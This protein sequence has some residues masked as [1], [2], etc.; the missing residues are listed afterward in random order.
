MLKKYGYYIAVFAAYAAAFVLFGFGVGTDCYHIMQQPA[1]LT[2]FEFFNEFPGVPGGIGEYCSCFVEQYFS[3]P[4]FGGFLL[5]VEILLSA[6][7]LI[8]LVGKIFRTEITEK[9][10]LWLVPLFVAV[11]CCNN[12]YFAFHIITQLIIMLAVSVLLHFLPGESRFFWLFEAIAA[13][14]VYH[15]CGPLYLYGFCSGG[16]ILQFLINSERKFVN[17]VSL[18]AVAGVYPLILYRFFLPLPPEPVFYSPVAMK[19][20]LEMYQPWIFMFYLIVPL[21]FVCQ[22]ISIKKR[23]NLWYA[24]SYAAMLGIVIWAYS[25][26]ESRRE[27]F[28]ARIICEAER[29]NWQYVIE[30][31]GKLGRYDRV[32]N[33]YYDLALAKTGLMSSK[34]FEYPQLLGN[35]GLL[36][37]EPL[38]GG[39]C[40][41]SSTQYF[42]IGQIPN[43]LRF[44][45]ESII[46]YKH[47]PYVLKRIIDCLIISEHYTEAEMF[48]K[49]LS[50]N[51]LEGDFVR[52]RR[53]YMRGKSDCQ[54]SDELVEEKQSQRVRL[55]YIMSPAFRNFEELLLAN[56]KNK[57]ATDYLLCYCMLDNDLENFVNTLLASDYSLKNLPKHYQEAVAVYRATSKNPNP[58]IRAAELDQTLVNRFKDFAK[59]ANRPDEKSYR[60]AKQYFNHTYWLYFVFE[61]PMRHNFSLKKHN[62]L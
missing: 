21:S 18:L 47:S 61:N 60:L 10:L 52:D 12:V 51:M 44:A 58:K 20:I 49:Q 45:Y 29:E 62:Q 40:F 8:V 42:Q 32:T 57:A 36:L 54:L 38:A 15:C 24:F 3:S 23:Q 5:T 16:I 43:S 28:S 14:M 30:N 17:C 56:P 9:S 48:L 25:D 4:V 7:L 19:T 11:V 59:L 13:V 39:L 2:D 55:D 31:A 22:R 34:L 27:R 1:F 50:R 41:H 6:W 33:F 35:E 26:S 37:E 53:R 46:Y